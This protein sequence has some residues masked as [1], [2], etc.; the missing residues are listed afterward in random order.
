MLENHSERADAGHSSMQAPQSMHFEASMTAMS[1]Q[2]M[3]PSGQTST[4]APHATHSDALTVTIVITSVSATMK[5]YKNVIGTHSGTR[6][7]KHPVG[8]TVGTCRNGVLHTLIL[9]P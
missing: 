3:A 2:E 8:A 5:P 6:V 1:S 4:H 9:P 7:A